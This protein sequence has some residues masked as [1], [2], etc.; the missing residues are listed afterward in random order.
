[1][2][3]ADFKLE[4]A[5]IVEY[6]IINNKIIFSGMNSMKLLYFYIKDFGCF[7]NREFNFDSRH[8]FHLEYKGNDEYIN[9]VLNRKEYQGNDEFSDL[10]IK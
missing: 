2:Q 9:A 5:S 7:K 4:F 6:F 3:Q 1:M 8:R 10:Q